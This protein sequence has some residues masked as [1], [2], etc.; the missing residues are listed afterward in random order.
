MELALTLTP[1]PCSDYQRF[2][3]GAETHLF[4]AQ[5]DVSALEALCV[6]RYTNR[7]LLLLYLQNTWW[8][9]GSYRVQSAATWF[10]SGFVL[11]EVVQVAE[12]RLIRRSFVVEIDALVV[13]HAVE[14]AS[15]NGA[16]LVRAGR[17]CRDGTQ[18][19]TVCCVGHRKEMHKVACCRD[20]HEQGADHQKWPPDGRRRDGGWSDCFSIRRSTDYISVTDN[21]CCGHC[22]L[23]TSS[24]SV[25]TTGWPKKSATIKYHH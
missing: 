18:R 11:F 22:C 14:W 6:M 21:G 25:L 20:P 9:R 17:R 8:F 4:A 13:G 12:G 3:I 2:Q 5:R 23:L 16:Y 1:G 15:R 10:H 7:L 19:C 24:A